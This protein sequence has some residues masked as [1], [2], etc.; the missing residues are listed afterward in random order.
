MMP[1]ALQRFTSRSFTSTNSNRH[2]NLLDGFFILQIRVMASLA[3]RRRPP[4]IVRKSKRDSIKDS[5]GLK[6]YGLDAELAAKD[7]KKFDAGLMAEAQQW[8]EILTGE[9]FPGDFMASLKDGIILCN[10]LNAIK[11]KTVKRISSS[12]LAF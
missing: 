7:A 5:G 3:N 8:L 2:C 4:P 10:A 1:A 9:P 6:L 11:P 12:K